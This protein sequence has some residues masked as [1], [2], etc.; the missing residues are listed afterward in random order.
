MRFSAP[1]LLGNPIEARL[2]PNAWGCRACGE[3]ALA[4]TPC[5]LVNRA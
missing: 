5:G 2:G 1:S 3:L 4:M